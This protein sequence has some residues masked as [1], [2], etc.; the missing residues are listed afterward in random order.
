MNRVSGYVLAFNVIFTW[1][2]VN[3]KPTE[4]E[5]KYPLSLAFGQTKAVEGTDFKI[6]FAAVLTDSRCPVD[7]Y[8]AWKGNARVEL[9]IM[10]VTSPNKRFA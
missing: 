1:A 10:Q 2:D 3:A 5:N 9:E 6:K 7:S 8:C 4:I